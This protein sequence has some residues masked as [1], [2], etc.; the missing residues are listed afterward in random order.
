MQGLP[1]IIPSNVHLSSVANAYRT[2]LPTT[3][4]SFEN[5]DGKDGERIGLAQLQEMRVDQL[6]EL[7][8][9]RPLSLCV[10]A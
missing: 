4:N 3:T 6:K 10:A 2:Y 1:P 5:M 7:V 9:V 8:K